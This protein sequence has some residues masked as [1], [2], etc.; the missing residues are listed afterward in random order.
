MRYRAILYRGL[1]Q[2]IVHITMDAL[3]VV[4]CNNYCNVIK[5][6]QKSA[7]ATNAH[8]FAI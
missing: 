3:F 4:I 5:L 8:L 2:Y 6:W 1:L 7:I